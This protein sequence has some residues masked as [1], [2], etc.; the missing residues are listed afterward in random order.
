MSTT[1]VG[2][3]YTLEK[4]RTSLDIRRF[5]TEQ[6]FSTVKDP[7][8]ASKYYDWATQIAALP[9]IVQFYDATGAYYDF[10][11]LDSV[12]DKLVTIKTAKIIVPPYYGSGDTFIIHRR[13]ANGTLTKIT[14]GNVTD[15][16]TLEEKSFKM[17]LKVT[18]STGLP[19]TLVLMKRVNKM[20]RKG[21][22]SADPERP[23]RIVQGDEM[24]AYPSVNQAHFNAKKVGQQFYRSH[25]YEDLF[26]TE[27]EANKKAES[28]INQLRALAQSVATASDLTQSFTMIPA[29]GNIQ[30]GEHVQLDTTG[31]VGSVKWEFVQNQ[32]GGS[33][34]SGGG[35]TSGCCQGTDIIIARDSNERT[36]QSTFTVVNNY[37]STVNGVI[38]WQN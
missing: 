27:D 15:Y 34:S 38:Q 16:R 30:V 37:S 29:G 32:T 24:Y 5:A 13:N 28:L 35:Y 33:L 12:T 11:D 25:T 26:A 9:H 7:N 1:T 19:T 23:Q 4:T 6:L 8:D 3:S 31:H 20:N 18:D 2:I 21:A 14:E 10:A 36:V 17:K 22:I